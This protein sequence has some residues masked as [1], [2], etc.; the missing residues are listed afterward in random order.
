MKTQGTLS[1]AVS[2]AI[3]SFVIFVSTA[4]AGIPANDNLANATLLVLSGGTIGV[5]T[6]NFSASKEIGEPNHAENSGGRSVWFSF[7]PTATKAIRINLVDTTFDTLLGVYTGSG[8]NNLQLVGYNDDCNNVCEQ[9]S[10]VELMM[11]AGT[12][13]YIAVDGFNDGNGGVGDGH[14][15][16]ALLELDAP[17]SDNFVSAQYLGSSFKVN[18]AG[19]NYSAT[20]EAGEPVAYTANPNGKSVWY[21]WTAPSSMSMAIE[22]TE[23]FASQVGIFGS[24]TGS[25][26]LADLFRVG[27]SIDG[28][29]ENDARYRA[30]FFAES[31]KTYYIKIDWHSGT[32]QP[33]AGNFQ[34]KLFPNRFRYS[35]KFSAAT[36][37]AG[38]AVFR[39]SDGVWYRLGG[40]PHQHPSYLKWGQ[41]G[42]TPIAA[43]F[44]GHGASG[45]AVVRNV[46]GQKVWYIFSGTPSGSSTTSV[47]AWG[48][49]TD[50]HLTGDFDND[51]RADLVALRSSGQNHVWYVRQSSNGVLRTFTFGLPTDKPV[52]GDFDGD[53]G[54]DVAV[55]RNTQQGWVWHILKSRLGSYD[56]YEAALFGMAPDIPAVEDFDGDG[57]T[58][59][60]VFRPS[61]G[62]WYILQ[63]SNGQVRTDAFGLSGDKPQPADFNGDGRA[64]LGVFRPSDGTWYIA[65]PQGIPGQNFHAIQWGASSDIPVTSMS[66]LT[67]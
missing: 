64:D 32:I 66:T 9:A 65:K 18:I 28:V 17:L 43:D 11:T 44:A 27:N 60:T 33:P 21:R 57:R 59:I 56:Q 6:N 24:N 39:P 53:G 34:L 16:I 36:Q 55:V 22:L 49:S 3:F 41:N 61:T 1:A 48:L 25:P 63:S 7:T 40:V 45:L 54:T 23:N 67:Q 14:F 50:K 13:Y 62:V 42:D 8:I 31:G 58:D 47:I 15:K 51:G 20:L 12:T 52:L 30:T 26:T 38:L 35:A 10:S 37:Y 29:H 2:V 46:N 5:T 19:T 4:T